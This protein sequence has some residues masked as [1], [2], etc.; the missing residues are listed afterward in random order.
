MRVKLKTGSSIVGKKKRKKS[1]SS[2]PPAGEAQKTVA[3][4]DSKR[5]YWLSK[6][7]AAVGRDRE[8]EALD[9]LERAIPQTSPTADSAVERFHWLLTRLPER[10]LV[11]AEPILDRAEVP[12]TLA[13]HILTLP[14]AV[15]DKIAVCAGLPDGWRA[16]AKALRLASACL[17]D[18]DDSGARTHL[19]AVG[20][21][22]PFRDGRM[23]LRGLSAYYND[24]TDDALRAFRRLADADGYGPLARAFEARL[25]ADR[26]DVDRDLSRLLDRLFPDEGLIIEHVAQAL[27][28]RRPNTAMSALRKHAASFS[29]GLLA[30]VRRGLPGA[31]LSVGVDPY[32]VGPRVVGTMPEDPDDPANLKLEA[33]INEMTCMRSVSITHWTRYA[34]FVEQ[35]ATDL[36]AQQIPMASAAIAHRV[37]TNLLRV[38]KDEESDDGRYFIFRRRRQSLHPAFGQA[39]NMLEA[40][41]RADPTC[42][43]Y[44]R[45]YLSLVRKVGNKGAVGRAHERFVKQFPHDPEA[46]RIGAEA[47]A[48]R[49]AWD[50]GLRYAQQAA[51]LEPLSRRAR[52]VEASMRVGKA[53]KKLKAGLHHVSRKL[54][55]AALRVPHCT[56]DVRLHNFAELALVEQHHGDQAA[57]AQVVKRA[58]DQ[59]PRPWLMAGQLIKGQGEI[60]KLLPRRGRSQRLLPEPQIGAWAYPP[61]DSMPTAEEQRAICELV[62]DDEL[63]AIGRDQM[64]RLLERSIIRAPSVITDSESVLEILDIIEDNDATYALATHGCELDPHEPEFVIDRYHAALQA[65]MGPQA[66]ADADRFFEGAI[67]RA[68]EAEETDLDD[69]DDPPGFEGFA[70]IARRIMGGHDQT[71]ADRLENLQARVKQYLG[72]ISRRKSP[73]KGKKTRSKRSP[74]TP[75]R[76]EPTSAAPQPDR[77]RPE[78]GFP[79]I[80]TKPPSKSRRR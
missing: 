63:S 10:A 54:Y 2:H 42:I 19:R 33:I 26:P 30:A 8:S 80:V 73:G 17:A 69:Y 79:E 15:F 36:P 66:F 74:A 62:D 43:D 46:L 13:A 32:A 6:A 48:E 58:L 78:F 56:P 27:R 14:D 7:D 9:C 35:G 59:D 50:K 3:P 22:S 47:A 29:P 25:G 18:G 57:A 4:S 31:L 45:L 11:E 61:D 24:Q 12:A 75:Q 5:A 20:L 21:R 55:E 60:S 34:N 28:G 38:V 64:I 37:V 39:V 53:R 76:S 67:E 65:E 70:S 51:E 52:D 41:L 44:W 49:G 16:E 77:A 68:D 1:R 72:R 71:T 40:V 23:F